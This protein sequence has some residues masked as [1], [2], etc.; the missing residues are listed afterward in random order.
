[1]YVSVLLILLA[2]ITCPND[3]P[4]ITD[5]VGTPNDGGDGQINIGDTGSYECE[6]NFSPQ[7][8]P[9]ITCNNENGQG[10]WGSTDFSCSRE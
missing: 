1:M 6:D 10:V 9:E 2:A 4:G 3:M 5:A 8:N 7:G